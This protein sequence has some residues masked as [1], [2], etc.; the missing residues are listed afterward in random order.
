MKRF[1]VY[2]KSK[3]GTLN[4]GRQAFS[5]RVKG[6]GGMAS[7]QAQEAQKHSVHHTVRMSRDLGTVMTP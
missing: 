3:A 2:K 7:C 6:H 1:I 4:L 5:V